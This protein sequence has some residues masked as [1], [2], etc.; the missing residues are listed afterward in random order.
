MNHTVVHL[1][2]HFSFLGENG[3][4]P[5]LTLY[6]PQNIAAMG[7]QDWLRPTILVCPGGA[8]S[9]IS[10]RES[11]P[12]ALQ[13]LVKGYN[14]LV[15][16]YS[17]APNCFPIQIREVAAAMELI[18]QNSAQWHCDTNR[19]AIMGFSAGGHLAAHYSTCYD[20]AEVREVFPD[21]KP[22]QAS[23]LGYPVITA[24]TPN[25][26][27]G[28]FRNVSGHQEPTRADLEK[29]SLERSVTVHTP[30]AFLWHTAEDGG[31]PVQ[32]SL[33]YAQALADHGIPF[34]LH[35]YPHGG[36]GLATVDEQTNNQLDP[37]ATYAADWIDA[38]LKWL[39]LT[40]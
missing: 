16:Q 2:E 23:I 7:R 37:K 39:K 20:C 35:V 27:R 12:I 6:L 13:F 11:E 32:N 33:I 19:V 31:V 28:S 17:C 29:F 22:V 26:H 24:F 1:K 4:D 5:K 8:Y 15:L 9:D 34:A 18:Y 36:H 30:P 38:A 3:C 25:Y 14:V 21:S 10:E 40:L